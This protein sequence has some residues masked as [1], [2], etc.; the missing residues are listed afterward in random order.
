MLIRLV[1]GRFSKLVEGSQQLN[2]FD[3]TPE[4]VSLYKA[5][6]SIRQRYGK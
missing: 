4:M 6:D 3:E 1:E 5:V 2:M